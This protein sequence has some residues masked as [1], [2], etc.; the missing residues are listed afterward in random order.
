MTYEQLCCS[1]CCCDNVPR[2]CFEVCSRVLHC[3]AVCC[4]VLQGV[5]VCCSAMAAETHAKPIRLQGAHDS[6]VCVRFIRA[7][8]LESMSS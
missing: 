1:V 4:S 8:A 6:V 7:C 5:A 2:L 3:V